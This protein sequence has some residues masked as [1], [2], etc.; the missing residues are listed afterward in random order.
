[1]AKETAKVAIS[2]IFKNKNTNKID[3]DYFIVEDDDIDSCINLDPNSN[4]N[5]K[6]L[7]NLDNMMHLAIKNYNFHSAMTLLKIG[8]QP[9]SFTKLEIKKM[10]EHP[11][12]K[13]E[14]KLEYIPCF[15]QATVKN[16]VEPI[17]LDVILTNLP[18]QYSSVS[19]L[20]QFTFIEQIVE[21]QGKGC[22]SRT[23]L[24]LMRWNFQSWSSKDTLDI[25]YKNNDEIYVHYKN[26]TE[27]LLFLGA[28]INIDNGELFLLAIVNQ[29]KICMEIFLK[30]PHIAKTWKFKKAMEIMVKCVDWSNCVEKMGSI[31]FR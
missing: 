1:M 2:N 15:S 23:L 3:D 31:L 10:F 4:P 8:A 16:C 7:S 14:M 12:F 27:K 17:W 13:W 26:L 18:H 28:D 11:K 24:A 21:S 25:I 19:L 22:A 9:V 5:Q 6:P 29:N 30:Q 20:K